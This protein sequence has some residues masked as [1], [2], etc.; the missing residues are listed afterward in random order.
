MN[1]SH[2]VLYILNFFIVDRDNLVR[3]EHIKKLLK[4]ELASAIKKVNGMASLNAK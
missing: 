3:D 1:T 4:E 2:I